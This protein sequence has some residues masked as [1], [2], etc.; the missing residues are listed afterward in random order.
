MLCLHK[1]L[2]DDWPCPVELYGGNHLIDLVPFATLSRGLQMNGN[3][4]NDGIPVD[5]ICLIFHFQLGVNLDSSLRYGH[6]DVALYSRD[7]NR[8][9]LPHTTKLPHSCHLATTYITKDLEHSST[10]ALG[11]SLMV[12]LSPWQ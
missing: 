12:L 11:D 4:I 3:N 5:T 7:H 8:T 9:P 6:D 2:L 10:V 1:W